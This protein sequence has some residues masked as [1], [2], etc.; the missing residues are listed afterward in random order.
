MT[1]RGTLTPTAEVMYD[2]QA[3]EVVKCFKLLGLPVHEKDWY[4]GCARHLTDTAER[5]MWATIRRMQDLSISCLDVK[6]RIFNT[7]VMS[8]GS[9]GCQVWGVDFLRCKSERD[10]FSNPLQGLVLKYLRIITG[11]NRSTSRWVLLRECGIQPVQVQW[12]CLCARKWNTEVNRDNL[13]GRTLKSDVHLFL[14]GCD[15]CWVGQFLGAMAGLGLTT[16]HNTARALRSCDPETIMRWKFE[17]DRVRKAYLGAHRVLTGDSS[18]GDDPRTA[19][20]RGLAVV[21]HSRWFQNDN[22]AHLLF[23][24]PEFC[25]KSLVRFRMGSTSS[26][27]V[28]DHSID[29]PHRICRKCRRRDIEDEKHVI[30]ECDLHVALRASARWSCL[31]EGQH[32]LQDMRSFMNQQDQYKLSF[33]IVNILRARTLAPDIEPL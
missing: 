24:A 30:F 31:F 5:A 6:I 10:V 18:V 1:P 9:Y 28:H 14:R 4:R 3:L 11:C 12:A 32:E 23:S 20:S 17:E 2:Q 25:I 13:T 27:R 15:K 19:P 26:L 29:R 8:V 33:F 16:G 21:R 22:N 7:M